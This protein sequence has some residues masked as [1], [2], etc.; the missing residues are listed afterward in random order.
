MS[1]ATAPPLPPPGR[2]GRVRCVAAANDALEA[3]VAQLRRR[4]RRRPLIAVAW[5]LALLLLPPAVVVAALSQSRGHILLFAC[6][7]VMALAGLEISWWHFRIRKRILVPLLHA[8]A[9]LSPADAARLQHHEMHGAAVAVSPLA[10]RICGGRV[11]LAALVITTLAGG[12]AVGIALAC[13][14]PL[15]RVN[16]TRLG[17]HML[18]GCLALGSTLSTLCCCFAVTACDAFVVLVYQGCFTAS[19]LNTFL[20]HYD[21]LVALYVVLVG[22]CLVIIGRIVANN[23]VLETM[24]T[25]ALDMIGLA[26]LALP[27]M[28]TADFLGHPKSQVLGDKISAFWIVICC[29]EIGHLLFTELRPRVSRVLGVCVMPLVKRPLSVHCDVEDLVVSSTG[30][31]VGFLVSWLSYPDH[32]FETWEFI[33]LSLAAVLSQICRLAVDAMKA[34]ANV[35]QEDSDSSGEA[36]AGAW[37]RNNG[38]MAR[39]SPYLLSVVIFHPYIKSLFNSS[40]G[41]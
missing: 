29:A 12:T 5:E 3:P 19:S 4:S 30:G 11:W 7:G 36:L 33:V 24:L 23:V 25:I 20:V 17:W 40:T 13:H 22:G 27:M 34:I 31:A 26:L 38:V 14:A 8:D 35:D 16:N 6:Q 1:D 28:E 39:A 10:E 9:H 21:H 41:V 18:L 37:L 15:E 2:P 32:Q